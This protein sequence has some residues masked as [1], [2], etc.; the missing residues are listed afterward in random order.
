MSLTLGIDPPG[1]KV[2]R[3]GAS[4]SPAKIYSGGVAAQNAAR[5]MGQNAALSSANLAK[6]RK[7]LMKCCVI[8]FKLL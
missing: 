7:T 1:Q 3:F 8:T 6:S 2:R 4:I 5:S